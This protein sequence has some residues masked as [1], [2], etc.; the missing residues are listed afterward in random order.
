MIPQSAEEVIR[1]EGIKRFFKKSVEN[2]LPDQPQTVNAM[3]ELLSRL[4]V[5]VDKD[6]GDYNYLETLAKSVAVEGEGSELV[7]KPKENIRD[8][9]NRELRQGARTITSDKAQRERERMV[10]KDKKL[11]AE[12]GNLTIDKTRRQTSVYVNGESLPAEFAIVP[13][14]RVTASH[15]EH[16]FEPNPEYEAAGHYNQRNYHSDKSLQ[17]S[18]VGKTE[19]ERLISN[20]VGSNEGTP[21]TDKDGFVM[22]G[23]NR[24]MRMKRDIANSKHQAYSDFLTKEAPIYG[25]SPEEV[26]QIPNPMLIRV[27]KNDVE[28]KVGI[29]AAFN[30]SVTLSNDIAAEATKRGN[31]IGQA[32]I[33]SLSKM[34]DGENLGAF[35]SN[36][37]EAVFNA[38]KN[39]G[40][41]ED[42]EISDLFDRRYNR[43]TEIGRVVAKSAF[44]GKLITDLEILHSLNP[45][46]ATK[47]TEMAHI[48]LATG[49]RSNFSLIK[50]FQEVAKHLSAL[51]NPNIDWATYT[52]NNLFGESVDPNANSVKLAKWLMERPVA[53]VRKG[54]SRYLKSIP[55]GGD[56]QSGMFELDYDKN[57]LIDE[58]ITPEG[59]KV[60]RAKKAE[61]QN[62]ET[63]EDDV[64]SL[65]PENDVEQEIIT[66]EPVMT[67]NELKQEAAKETELINSNQSVED[68][69]LGN[70]YYHVKNAARSRGID[71][72]EILGEA[73][74]NAQ[75]AAETFDPAKGDLQKR[76]IDSIYRTAQAYSKNQAIQNSR[77]S[78]YDPS[79][80]DIE[81]GK[82]TSL[83]EKAYDKMNKDISKYLAKKH[84]ELKKTFELSIKGLTQE[85][86]ANKIGVRQGTVSKHL[87]RINSI[88]EVMHI[89]EE[90]SG[91]LTLNQAA[92]WNYK[93]EVKEFVDRVLDGDLK[94]KA[95]IDIGSDYAFAPDVSFQLPSDIVKHVEK[96]HPESRDIWNDIGGIL[97]N[98]TDIEEGRSS[99]YHG[100]S[101][102][103]KGEYSGKAFGLVVEIAENGKG[104]ITTAFF[105]HQ[106]SINS[107][108]ENSKK[109]SEGRVASGQARRPRNGYRVSPITSDKRIILNNP[110]SVNKNS[111]EGTT[112]NQGKRGEIKLYPNEFRAFIKIFKDGK[113]DTVIHEFSHLW[114]DHVNKLIQGGI[115]DPDSKTGQIFSEL[116]NHY[117]KDTLNTDF[118]E[119]FAEDLTQYV[120]NGK[121]PAPALINAFRVIRKAVLN[122]YKFFKQKYGK[123]NLSPEITDIFNRMLATDD[124][125]EYMGKYYEYT[126][127]AQ[128]VLD[129]VRTR[130]KTLHIEKNKRLKKEA[131]SEEDKYLQAKEK[132]YQK[133]TNVFKNNG[134]YAKAIDEAV[135]AVNNMPVYK[136][137]DSIIAAGR[138]DYKMIKD[139]YG[140]KVADA[141]KRH[142]KRVPYTDKNGN[143]S[144]KS[145]SIIVSR[146][147]GNAEI[148]LSQIAKENGFDHESE[149]EAENMLIQALVDAPEKAK[150]IQEAKSEAKNRINTQIAKAVRESTEMLDYDMVDQLVIDKLLLEDEADTLKNAGE[151]IEE[152][153]IRWQKRLKQARME[154]KVIDNQGRDIINKS[155]LSE[156][157]DYK[158]FRQQLKK[159]IRDV[160]SKLKEI[161]HAREKGDTELEAQL[162]SEAAILQKKR[163]I[164]YVAVRHSIHAFHNWQ[165][166]KAILQTNKLAKKIKNINNKY[167]Q[168]IVDIL[169]TW[170]MPAVQNNEK[171]FRAANI[172][173]DKFSALLIIPEEAT[174]PLNEVILF[175]PSE[176]I[177]NWMKEKEASSVETAKEDFKNISYEQFD[178]ISSTLKMLLKKGRKEF[179]GMKDAKITTID[180]AAQKL[181]EN[182]DKHRTINPNN[183]EGKGS[184]NRFINIKHKAKEGFITRVKKLKR[185]LG[186]DFAMMEFI[187]REM[188]DYE[189]GY[190][191]ENFFDKFMDSELEFRK[192]SKVMKD[193]LNPH[194]NTLYAEMRRLKRNNNGNER[195]NIEGVVPPELWIKYRSNP[196]FNAHF[197]AEN[198]IALCFNMGNDGNLYSVVESLDLGGEEF[199]EYYQDLMNRVEFE[200]RKSS[201]LQDPDILEEASSKAL[202][203][204]RIE[205][206]RPY[207]SNI[208]S[209]LSTEGWN[210]IQ[211]T[212][213]SLA[214]IFPNYQKAFY[215]TTGR[216]LPE[217][218]ATPLTI[219]TVD[220][221]TLNLDGGYYPLKYDFKVQG[222]EDIKTLD[223]MTTAERKA[224]NVSQGINKDA[225]HMR[226][227]DKMGIATVGRMPQLEVS[228]VLS[229]HIADTLR[230][231]THAVIS[232]DFDMLLRN[233]E[234]KETFVDKFG[235]E[236]YQK[237][238]RWALR[239]ARPDVDAPKTWFEKK[240]NSLR[241]INTV[242]VLGMN[243]KTAIKQLL[244][245]PLAMNEMSRISEGKINGYWSFID[246]AREVARGM[247]QGDKWHS[248]GAMDFVREAS[249]YIRFREDDAYSLVLSDFTEK[250]SLQPKLKI[251]GKKIGKKELAGFSFS[252][253]RT[254]DRMAVM[255]IWLGAFNQSLEMNGVTRTED[256]KSLLNP[257]HPQSEIIQKC[258]KQA[259][260]VVR[261][262]QPSTMAPDLSHAQSN[263]F[264]KLFTAFS[265]YTLKAF[266]RTNYDI[267][268]W[269]NGKLGFDELMH[270]M[271][272]SYVMPS[273]MSSIVALLLLPEEDE[274]EILDMILDPAFGQWKATVPFLRSIDLERL[275][276]NPLDITAIKPAQEITTGFQQL[277]NGKF[278]KGTKTLT[279]L[280]GASIGL[281]PKMMLKSGEQIGELLTQGELD[282]KKENRKEN[283]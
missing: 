169:Y 49:R 68:I 30:S 147:K 260:R 274:P 168:S 204:K 96:S 254:A 225:T 121:A 167:A 171:L 136:T 221:S 76:I 248:N 15:N 183:P 35:I 267:R 98:V 80:K 247:N 269:R 237:L 193:K 148:D 19:P 40:V 7:L 185:T 90:A 63:I 175:N 57:T 205:Y 216:S 32:T 74:E 86:I 282:S 27:L 206:A 133:L 20:N 224:A 118:H 251:A 64:G 4:F 209:M 271:F 259:D 16:T 65:F 41:I 140:S 95:Y 108:F 212:W 240:I 53:E 115:I 24:S 239:Q 70:D 157:I 245:I 161:T 21:I 114:L 172:S 160:D 111:D 202:Y 215:A 186:A 170:N 174:T 102:V 17:E 220:G 10:A 29:S 6:T 182:T 261:S 143:T 34:N 28:D 195:F 207:L 152:A 162:L 211:N 275:G 263:A 234:F 273:I 92:M 99:K 71:Y 124:E 156:A 66:H 222:I 200:K 165:N 276:S 236:K 72:Q 214:T 184:N 61:V 58:M 33:N 177:P 149:S 97:S 37:Q 105:D 84:K 233:K 198:I 208:Q 138:L 120:I 153:K 125:I 181:K 42:N 103:T 250:L 54:L 192:R 31:L 151:S 249:D 191:T 144:Y 154:R 190:F 52:N 226:N 137:V 25:Y 258:I 279:N 229:T 253:I 128:S 150:V 44:L 235:E 9:I 132:Y 159:A 280:A 283:K 189:V 246:G 228:S 230:Y 281:S 106:N 231:S 110:D 46:N 119:D 277:S 88:P 12:N 5:A 256:Y 93:G 178:D 85:D 219:T 188:D 134:G 130:R 173:P 75:K 126:P 255:P 180:E 69:V 266:N 48:V 81:A 67:E 241:S 45:A 122:F 146:S 268:A 135:N 179:V 117:G 265:T 194:L 89:R 238:S 47:I 243:A 142:K 242:A 91:M 18:L 223:A 39:D 203:Q 270:S 141:L 244:S 79:V 60:S 116:M 127:L 82:N 196:N 155:R 123:N 158:N 218:Q 83:Y 262:T 101:F 87:D 62:A 56:T 213:D 55:S 38:L 2:A 107:W 187:F 11:I 51:Q 22:S 100:N 176:L 201:E 278:M 129:D 166:S 217:E 36:N 94:S 139:L 109:R 59:I 210:A 26:A 227:R 8:I 3:V 131:I 50:D 197:T 1:R 264:Y 78:A 13:A 199:R 23:N 112:L 145:V 77:E 164:A 14:D 257:A 73:W 104:F 272:D 163:T 252:L 232:N 113:A 43:F